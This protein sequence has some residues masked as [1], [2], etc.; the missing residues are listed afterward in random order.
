MLIEGAQDLSEEVRTID[1]KTGGEKGVKKIQLGAVDPLA[2]MEIGAVAGFG[3]TKY[4]RYNFA[5]G[6][7]W[8]YSYDALQRHLHQWWNGEDK[9]KESGLSHLAHAAWHCLALMTFQ[10]RHRGTDDRFPSS[11]EEKGY[12]SGV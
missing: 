2:L 10:F 4:E 9:D 1:P 11:Y 7:R 8:S 5:R 6:Y 12:G 3:A